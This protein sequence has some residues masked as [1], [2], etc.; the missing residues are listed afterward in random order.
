MYSW[1]NMN[2]LILYS[3]FNQ[4]ELMHH[5]SLELDK[6]DIKA[7][8][9]CF[10]NLRL[11]KVSSIKWPKQIE[12]YFT[13]LESLQTS[14]IS[15][16]FRKLLD[17][18]F[19]KKL[20]SVY[21]LVDFHAYYPY[22][23]N[24]MREC[25]RAHIKFDIT[26]W[27]SDLMRATKERKESQ[28][29]GFDNCYRIKLSDNL[30]DTMKQ[31][32]G[33][34]YE[35]KCRIVYFGN[36]DLAYIDNL[37]DSE[38]IEIMHTLCGEIGSKKIIV[39]GYNGIPSQNHEKMIEALQ[40]LSPEEKVSLHVVLPM[41]YGAESEYFQKIEVILKLTNVSFTILN[42]FLEKEQVA[43]LRKTADIVVNIQNTDAIA[44]S[45]QDHL[46]CGN[47]CI[48]GEWLNYR[49]YDDN[50]IFYIKTSMDDI[51]LHIKDVLHNYPAYK[52]S[53]IGNHN[54]IRELFSWESNIQKQVAVY[55]E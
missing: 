22:Y 30:F 42:K 9:L 19:L 55:A 24:L 49:V 15:R 21:D 16:A 8:I 27:G 13:L 47:V 7:D 6:Y 45:L 11:E 4:R 50:N 40:N 38:S 32:Y 12:Y 52:D 53:C 35:E 41:T 20:I 34:D 25:I 29:Y 23:N 10:S 18:F 54:K 26:L 33:N 48:F 36:N 14:W 3:F 2:I 37:A 17:R 5:F 51:A 39:L 46:Y 43:A 44:A 31:S 28:R 1:F